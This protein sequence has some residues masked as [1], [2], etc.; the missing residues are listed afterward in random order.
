M[1]KRVYGRSPSMIAK[2]IERMSKYNVECTSTLI[3]RTLMNRPA[4]E[5]TIRGI[6]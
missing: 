5:N 2:H 6:I 1:T 3:C 4:N